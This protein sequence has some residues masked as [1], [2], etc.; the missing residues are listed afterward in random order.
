MIVETERRRALAQR[1]IEAR[2]HQQTKIKDSQIIENNVNNNNNNEINASA[3]I[4][5][6]PSPASISSASSRPSVVVGSD[7]T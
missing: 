7:K 2:L 6:E 1:A 4:I 5:P 3:E